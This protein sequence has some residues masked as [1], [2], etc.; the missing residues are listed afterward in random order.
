MCRPVSSWVGDHQR[1][2][3]VDCFF[4]LLVGV[5]GD[6]KGSFYLTR[7]RYL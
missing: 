4:S 5:G 2:P 1:I 7:G 3:A 6:E